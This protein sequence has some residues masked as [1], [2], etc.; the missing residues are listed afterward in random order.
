VVGK[1]IVR[2][3]TLLWPAMLMSAGIPLPKRVFGHGFVQVLSDDMGVEE[4]V[5]MS[6]SLGNIVKP[7]DISGKYGVDALRYFLMKEIPYAGDGAYS[8]RNLAMR[9]NTDLANDLGNL[10]LRTLSMIERYVGGRIPEG[11]AD[12]VVE[13]PDA[14]K[15]LHAVAEEVA[16]NVP[17]LMEEL[18]F[19]A[20]LEAI[21][22]LV[23]AANRYVEETKP[24][25]LAKDPASRPRLGVVLYQLA[26]SCRLLSIWLSP[27]VPTTA[28]KIR[29]QF[30]LD[31]AATDFALEAAWGG[32]KPGTM[33]RKGEPLFPRLDLPGTT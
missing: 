15:V 2:F 9:Y 23:R 28:R 24:W 1:D 7:G 21:W 14:D 33:I 11:H 20:A 31:E 26:E 10:V 22:S 19:S 13:W 16:E 3:H 27:F 6:K 5:K 17:A 32:T 4:P 8:E 25:A 12:P 18:S 30:A 29:S